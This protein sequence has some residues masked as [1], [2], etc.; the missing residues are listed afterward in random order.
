MNQLKHV[1]SKTASETKA[2]LF[3]KLSLTEIKTAQAKVLLRRT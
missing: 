2:Q 1:G 3:P